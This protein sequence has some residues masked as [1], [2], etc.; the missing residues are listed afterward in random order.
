MA[1][2]VGPTIE[3]L[4]GYAPKSE[5]SGLCCW[6]LKKI[7]GVRLGRVR[8]QIAIEEARDPTVKQNLTAALQL[9]SE[10]ADVF[11]G[12]RRLVIDDSTDRW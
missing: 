4:A 3:K 5:G 11:F 12:L 2:S 10:Y 7:L 9:R 1:P 8:L 6:V